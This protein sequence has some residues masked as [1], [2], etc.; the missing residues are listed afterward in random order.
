MNYNLKKKENCNHQITKFPFCNKCCC[1][2]NPIKNIS[3]INKRLNSIKDEITFG[4]LFKKMINSTDINRNKFV[5]LKKETLPNI[6]NRKD[7]IEKIFKVITI[8]KYSLSTFYLSIVLLDE[9]FIRNKYSKKYFISNE[10]IALG[11]LILAI[12][13]NEQENNCSISLSQI[14]YFYSSSI[15]IPKGRLKLLEIL[16]LKKL[17]YNIYKITPYDYLNIFIKI[18]II[19]NNEI[20]ENTNLNVV[21]LNS[22]ISN[23]S[24]EILDNLM[25]NSNEYFQ[26]KSYLIS[27]GILLYAKEKIMHC[28]NI[29]MFIYAYN[30]SEKE[31][32]KTKNYVKENCEKKNKI[33]Y[34]INY[35][36]KNTKNNNLFKKV[37]NNSQSP[38][39]KESYKLQKLFLLRP[40]SLTSVNSRTSSKKKS[41]N[42]G[43]SVSTSSDE[44]NN[45][46]INHKIIFSGKNFFLKENTLNYSFSF[47]YKNSN[48]SYRKKYIL[49]IRPFS[50]ILEKKNSC[51]LR[52]NRR[53]VN[54]NEINYNFSQKI[55]NYRSIKELLK[56]KK[57]KKINYTSNE[58]SY[59]I[60]HSSY[61]N[62]SN[63]KNNNN[64]NNNYNN[65]KKKLNIKP[66][67]LNNKNI[68]LKPKEIINNKEKKI[69]NV[70]KNS[71]NIYNKMTNHKRTHSLSTFNNIKDKTVLTSLM[72]NK[73]I[74]NYC[75][76]VNR[77]TKDL[78]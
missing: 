41:F 7:I 73:N 4:T 53:L 28:N 61:K 22:K 45:G 76:I 12:K 11:S 2:Y 6:K 48:N 47:T 14:N 19:F 5:K 49:N 32:L 9:I 63:N 13:C 44:F 40:K 71:I 43:S 37:K 74:L 26:I 29:E 64:N 15:K 16:C 24:Y 56:E 20:Q 75:K 46:I 35:K 33:N 52:N 30:I 50:Q 57:E 1:I 54:L 36:S 23:F 65:K 10:E 8:Y 17:N 58:F 78:Y 42:L 27:L 25:R 38:L 68:D 21:Y 51:L 18:G 72:K 59:L 67:K 31:L 60:S 39:Q 3:S 70:I 34:I 69:N 66:Y 77:K 62:K 55:K